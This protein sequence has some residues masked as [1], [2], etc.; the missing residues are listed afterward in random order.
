MAAPFAEC[1]VL[2]AI[3]TYL[4][5]HVLKRRVIFVDL[6]LAQI[7]A[8]GRTVGF[9]FGIVHET[10]AA[11][12]FSVGFTIVG[13]AVFSLTRFRRER[14]PQEAIIGLAY[15][16]SFALAVLVVDKTKG[17]EHLE[18]ILVGNLLWVRWSDVLSAAVVY[19]AVGLVHFLFRRKF[20]HI[21]DDPEGAFAAG[22]HV[23]AWDFLFYFTFGIVIALS[24][25]VA[26]VLL[27]F[28]FLVGPPILGLL[29]TDRLLYQLIV[30]WLTGTVVTVA[31][32]FLSW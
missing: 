14:V 18:D 12:I 19:A 31:G 28:V 1:L 30:G 16:I 21:S 27:V 29:L 8:L 20:L 32:L 13:A 25:H 17:A 23:R 3:H 10:P 26:G 24:T 5:I 6:A 2:V 22:V 9:L 7:A 4:G 15:A 11:L